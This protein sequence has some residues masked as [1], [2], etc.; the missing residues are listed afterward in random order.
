MSSLTLHTEIKSM[1]TAQTRTKSISMLTLKP[2][3][4]RP[5]SKNRVNFDH[6][7][8]SKNQV[9]RSSH[10][11]QVNFGPHTVNFAPPHTKQVNFDPNIKTKSNSI[12]DT[13]IKLISTPLLKICQFDPRSKIKP[14]SMPPHKNQV[15][16]DPHTKTKY[17][18]K[19]EVNPDLCAKSNQFR[20]P[21]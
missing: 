14:I 18:S 7:R 17:P 20:S 11:K 15:N 21:L 16:F 2:S 3:D 9:N 1:S 6:H 12:P 13:K 4:W 19:N 5:A 10:S 8:P